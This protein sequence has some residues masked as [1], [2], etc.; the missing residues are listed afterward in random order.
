MAQNRRIMLSLIWNR[1]FSNPKSTIFGVS[2]G[3][4]LTV[5]GTIYQSAGCNFENVPWYQVVTT[6]GLGPSLVGAL[7]TD[8]GKSDVKSNVGA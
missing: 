3:A 1:V 5:I 2:V 4:V 6:L 7:L 8:N